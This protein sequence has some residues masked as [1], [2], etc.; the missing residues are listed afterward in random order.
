MWNMQIVFLAFMF[1]ASP[2]LAQTVKNY[3]DAEWAYIMASFYSRH[4]Y[5]VYDGPKDSKIYNSRGIR[6]FKS[7]KIDL[8]LENFRKAEKLGNNK[9]KYFM[10]HLCTYG[11]HVE[12]NLPEAFKRYKELARVG[13]FGAEYN[14]AVFYENG[15][16]TE[17]DLQKAFQHYRNSVQYYQPNSQATLALAR[18]YLA[19][20]G[21]GKN[22]ERAIE[23]FIKTYSLGESQGAF[24]VALIYE[25]GLLG[26][27]DPEKAI[28]WYEN[29]AR[30]GDGKSMHYLAVRFEKGQI[31]PRDLKKA[32]DWYLAAGKAGY[33]ESYYKLGLIL[34]RSKENPQN[35]VEA[36]NAFAKSAQ[37]G[38]VDAMCE[39]AEMYLNGEGV[40]PSPATAAKWLVLANKEKYERAQFQ[41]GLMLIEGIGVTKDVKLG[42]SLIQAAADARYFKALEWL[43]K[44]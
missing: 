36:I 8:A 44:H 5:S 1:L 27:P 20:R 42:E 16:G 26:K 41:L 18:M 4:G 43:E 40:D 15:W 30:L 35:A 31:V 14:L 7:G 28:H 34:R 6:Y 22:T 33:T 25:K 11:I 17:M 10:A 38:N 37:A 24:N 19:G 12:R 9:S 3:S 2:L 13:I 23:L 21:C 39:I 29:A 32:A